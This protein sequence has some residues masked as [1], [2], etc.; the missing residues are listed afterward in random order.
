RARGPAA[1]GSLARVPVVPRGADPAAGRRSAGGARAGRAGR[2]VAPGAGALRRGRRLV[3]RGDVRRRALGRTCGHE[4]L[5]LRRTPAHAGGDGPRSRGPRRA[6]EPRVHRPWRR[7]GA[8]GVARLGRRAARRRRCRAG[9]GRRAPR[10]RTL[11]RAAGP[12]RGG[13]H[14]ALARGP[15]RPAR[16]LIGLAGYVQALGSPVVWAALGRTLLYACYVPVSMGLALAL[17]LLLRGP[18][19]GARLVR[20]LL[21]LPAVSSVVAVAL[22]WRS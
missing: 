20:G 11:G 5:A 8:R 13:R 4:S 6:H 15:A 22:V 2:A 18:S 21:F 14:R 16:P 12:P 7:A 3:R 17:A 19:R 1:R 9:R 10:A